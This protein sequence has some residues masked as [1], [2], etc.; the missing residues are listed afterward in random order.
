[1][2]TD[3]K[4]G[5]SYIPPNLPSKCKWNLSESKEIRDSKD[6]HFHEKYEEKRPKIL[7]NI[8]SAIGNT[9]LV[10]LNK[11]PKQYGLKCELLA[12]C[13]FFN[14]G[15]SVKDRIVLKMIL[16]AER[17]GLISEG[18]T[19]IEPSSGN[20]GIGLALA[21]A[22]KG[23][24]C[25]I[26][27]PERMSNEK[28]SVLHALG[29]K[30]IRTPSSARYDSPN[31]YIRVAQKL[32]QQI[33]N[34]IVLDQYRNAANPLAHYDSTAEE[35]LK[36]TDG[37]VDM[38]VIG[39]GTGGTVTGIGRKFKEVIPE[40]QVVAVDPFGSILAEPESLTKSSTPLWELEGI[41]YE[42]IPTVLDRT[43]VDKWIK[44]E[45]KSSFEMA[46][47]LIAEEGL[48]CGGSSGSAVVA[49]LEAAKDLKEGQRCVVILPDGVRNYLTKF[50]DDNWMSERHFGNYVNDD[51]SH[52]KKA[53]FW[54]ES[55]R[56][57]VKG[58]NV[59][60]VSP[61]TK[62]FE[63]I[64]IMKRHAYDQ[65]AVLGQDNPILVGMI[66][67]QNILTNMSAQTLTMKSPISEVMV[68]NYPKI[69]INAKLG[70]ILRILKTNPYVVVIDRVSKTDESIAGI[71]THIDILNYIAKNRNSY[72]Q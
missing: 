25:V 41:G 39:A 65:L 35:V 12:K 1:M 56:E 14:A 62:C 47:K 21:C 66:T 71:I 32:C 15:G 7:P 54:N 10:R 38:I 37:K 19:I 44:F 31:S 55:I 70:S 51:D 72:Q 22:V 13:E 33:K 45:D 60:S 30:I 29:A 16:D 8:L 58:M 50:L 20:T 11:I 49:A 34:S 17:D 69:E 28:V 57:L 4:L 36:Q 52:H 27:L 43:V 5:Y 6:P 48:L 68:K 59:E 23:Y 67:V 53:W 64:S 3:L 18:S 2:S 61:N 46:R 9:P 40:C 24:K 63:A 42:F 26:V